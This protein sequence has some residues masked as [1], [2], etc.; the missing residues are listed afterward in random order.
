MVG[1]DVLVVR[2]GGG[3]RLANCPPSSS[4]KLARLADDAAT[5]RPG[6]VLAATTYSPKITGPDAEY[7]LVLFP[8]SNVSA[9]VGF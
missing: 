8:G 3:R 4:W 1:M 6:T 2:V 7:E 5:S 9:A